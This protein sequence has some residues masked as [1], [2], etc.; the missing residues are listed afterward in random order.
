MLARTIARN[1]LLDSLRHVKLKVKKL[2]RDAETIDAFT[3][4]SRYES[5]A[6]AADIEKTSTFGDGGRCLVRAHG[7]R[8]TTMSGDRDL[9]CP[10]NDTE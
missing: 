10:V 7:P 8:Q 2:E 1:S 3:I 6:T 4:A 5:F 9:Q